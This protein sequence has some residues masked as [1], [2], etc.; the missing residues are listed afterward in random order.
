MKKIFISL[1]LLAC[2]QMN[3]QNLADVLRFSQTPLNGSARFTAM[4]GAFGAV[5]GDFSALEINPAGSAIFAFSEAGVTLNNYQLKNSA[6]YTNVSTDDKNQNLNIGQLGVVLLLNETTGGGWS[7][8]AFG[9]TYNK[10]ADYDRSFVARGN[11]FNGIDQYFL[12]NAE[13]RLLVDISR[14]DDESL[15]DAY[16]DISTVNGLGYSGVQA[17]LGYEGYVVNPMPIAGEEP[18]SD[19]DPERVNRYSSNTAAGGNGYQHDY[20]HTSSGQTK[21]YTFNLSSSYNDR[22]FIGLN[23]NSYDLRY[24]EVVD[25]YEQGYSS[26]SGIQ[27]LRF[28]NELTTAG[29]GGAFQLGMIYKISPKIR[30]GLTLDSPTYFRLNDRVGQFLETEVAFEN[31]ITSY[32]LDPNVD[33]ILPEYRFISPGSIRGSFS[34]IIGERGLISVDY[35]EK[36]LSNTAFRA[37]EFYFN[38]DL[39]SF[40][41]LIENEFTPS[42]IL[43]VGG[44]FR[45]TPF[46]SLRA[47]YIAEDATLVDFDN[48]R[49]V[50]S[51]GF[52][53][54]FGASTLDV[55]LQMQRFANQQPLFYTGLIDTVLLSSERNNLRITYR[56]KL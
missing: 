16:Y 49:T 4:G 17:L 50:I 35:T 12:S 53:Y 33:L 10:S 37:D 15:Q 29:S 24:S 13:G 41:S 43:Q 8:L 31:E 34:Y 38:E 28:Y 3:A 42:T 30:V 52:G 11:N 25:F 1:A 22:F 48:S 56:I 2:T 14:L 45:L 32:L 27:D 20:Y 23:I 39:K 9:F 21:K 40:N 18:P 26:S 6:A 44:E 51:A 7:K 46:L 55:S 47:G 54:S 36:N 5:G 19:L